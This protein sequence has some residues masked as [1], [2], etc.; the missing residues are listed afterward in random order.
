[1]NPLRDSFYR[2]LN[3]YFRIKIDDRYMLCKPLVNW[4]C[5]LRQTQHHVTDLFLF[6]RGLKPSS[7]HPRPDSW[8][9]LPPPPCRWGPGHCRGTGGHPGIERRQYY[10]PFKNNQNLVLNCYVTSISSPRAGECGW[11]G[12]GPGPPALFRSQTPA[13]PRPPLA[14]SASR[15]FPFTSQTR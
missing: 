2:L 8:W 6:D 13:T 7:I 3:C 11:A 14:S 15:W 1:M 12:R 5:C 4:L 9:G 10:S